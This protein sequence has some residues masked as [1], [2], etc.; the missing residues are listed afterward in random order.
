MKRLHFL[1]FPFALWA[2]LTLAF[3]IS[4]EARRWVPK[5]AAGAA[6]PGFTYDVTQ[7]FEAAL[8]GDWS[9]TDASSILN[10]TDTAAK[11]TS[12]GGAQGM[13]YAS[14]TTA[15]GQAVYHPASLPTTLSV[16][17]WFKSG[18]YSNFAGNAAIFYVR[19]T[20]TGN[21]LVLREGDDAGSGSRS[22]AWSLDADTGGADVLA[23]ATWYWVTVLWVQNGTCKA[24]FYNTSFAQVGAELSATGP[25]TATDELWFGASGVS[26]STALYWDEIYINTTSGTFPLGPAQ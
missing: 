5:V 10:P 24:R 1:G 16:G 7:G 11:Y 15:D 18:T 25:N 13:S 8:A 2:C 23:S 9:E 22:F 14:G 3:P 19:N 17:F 26:T 6:Y 4:A 21:L 12:N 20:G